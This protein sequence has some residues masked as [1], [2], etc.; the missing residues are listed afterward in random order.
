MFLVQFQYCKECLLRHFHVSNLF[1]SFLTSFLFLKQLTLTA[2]VTTITLGGYILT[3]L[4]YCFAGNNLSTDSSLNSDIKLL[5]R[6]ELLQLR[7]QT[8]S[9]GNGTVLMSKCRQSVDRF[10]IK[11]DIELSKL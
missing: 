10:T 1:H 8:A 11:Q 5:T 6:D 3:N 7:A 9:K 2:H 4:L